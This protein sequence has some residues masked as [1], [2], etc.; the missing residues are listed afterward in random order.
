MTAGFLG[1]L[2]LASLP[3]RVSDE[4]IFALLLE[5]FEALGQD[6]PP[7]VCGLWGQA[8]LLAELGLT[9][10]LGLC[11]GCQSAEV[12][13]FSALEGGVLCSQC[14]SG[15]GFALTDSALGLCRSLCCRELAEFEALPSPRDMLVAG[16]LL[17]DQFLAHAGLSASYFKRVLPQRGEHRW[18]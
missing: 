1:R 4:S 14:Y 9:P 18:D 3:E 8:R 13:G 2:F 15:H 6:V 12:A 7:E 11:L 16:R 17:K 5:L 10:E